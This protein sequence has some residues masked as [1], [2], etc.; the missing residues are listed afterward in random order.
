M[1]I[2]KK[3]QDLD[4]S[5]KNLFEAIGQILDSLVQV[6]EIIVFDISKEVPKSN[7]LG[8]LENELRKHDKITYAESL[9]NIRVLRKT[10][11]IKNPELSK[12][13]KMRDDVLKFIE[14]TGYTNQKYKIRVQYVPELINCSGIDTSNGFCKLNLYHG[15]ISH[16][17]C[18]SLIISAS[19]KED[20]FE[21]QVFN[22]LVRKSPQ[23]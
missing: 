4:L 11:N 18:S 22:A 10:I 2:L 21:G 8:D 13:I 15:S 19:I 12:V 1:T 9:S 17:K 14:S 20:G 6:I 3:L 23:P 7:S 16:I 5:E